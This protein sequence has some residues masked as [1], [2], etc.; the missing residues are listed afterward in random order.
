MPGATASSCRS[1]TSSFCPATA[2]MRPRPC[3]TGS[4][5]APGRSR[6]ARLKRRLLDM[7]GALIRIAAERQMRAAPVLTPPEGLYGEFSARFPYE[8]T[9]DQQ[10][11]IDVVMD[12]LVAGRPMDRLICGDVGFGKTEVALRAAF[13][14]AMEGFQVAVVVPT[15]LLARQHFKTFSQRF[16]G[17]P[18]QVGQA[19]RLVGAKDARRDQE[20]HR[21]RHDR[22]RRRHACAA[23][24]VDLVQGPRPADRRRGAAFRGQAQGAAEGAEERRACADAVGDAD[25]AHAA[26]GADRRARAV[27]DRHAAGRPHGGAHLHLALR[28][29]WSSARRCCASA[30]AAATVS[31]SCRASPISPRSMTSSPRRCRS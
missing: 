31:M 2:R 26:A 10:T 16:A 13:V 24:Q 11:A 12:D 17:L 20:G 23:R 6:K 14:A 27:A 25:P 7:A 29:R 4:A 28:L 3:S 18:V 15:T 21:R 8:E 5:A 30:I 19:S 22:H 9:D 1:K